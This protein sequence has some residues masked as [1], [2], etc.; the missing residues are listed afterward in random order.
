MSCGKTHTRRQ[1]HQH[2]RKAVV[3][4]HKRIVIVQSING[5]KKR[6]K[7]VKK[8][9]NKRVQARGFIFSM[10]ALK[11]WERKHPFKNNN[12][13]RVKLRYAAWTKA[14]QAAWDKKHPFK[15]WTEAQWQAW[16]KKHH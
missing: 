13:C 10:K 9:I 15:P 6:R 4:R 11:A 7:A 2:R 14:Q 5:P 1:A 8:K 12:F 3:Q 16:F